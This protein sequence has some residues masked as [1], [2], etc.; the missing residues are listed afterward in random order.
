M[1][2]IDEFERLM[3]APDLAAEGDFDTVAGLV[4][5]L[6]QRLP[7]AGDKAERWPLAFEIVDLDGRR[8]DKLIVRRI[9]DM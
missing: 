9:E 5:H 4:I 3:S 2:P 1:M 6:T 7:S 8:V